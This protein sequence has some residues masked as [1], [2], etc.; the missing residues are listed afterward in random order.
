MF[1]S[2]YDEL[3]SD[4][5]LDERKHFSIVGH[6]NGYGDTADDGKGLLPSLVEGR[7]DDDGVDIVLE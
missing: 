2:L 4:G 7:N 3:G 1:R 6:T 5:R